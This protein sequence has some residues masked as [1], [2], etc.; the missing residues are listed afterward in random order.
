MLAARLAGAG[1]A[2]AVVDALLGVEEIFGSLSQS[3]DLRS[4]LIDQ[5]GRIAR[6]G[7]RAAVLALD[8]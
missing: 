4:L 3:P 2:S 7:A 5:L 1:D 8:S 6:D